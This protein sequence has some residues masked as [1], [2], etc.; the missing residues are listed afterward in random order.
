MKKLLILGI[1]AKLSFALTVVP[2]VILPFLE[3]FK[4]IDY[5]QLK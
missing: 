3:Q 4:S 1:F 5:L 2:M